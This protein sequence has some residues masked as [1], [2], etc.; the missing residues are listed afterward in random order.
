MVT[1]YAA[2]YVPCLA[3]T[4]ESTAL[5]HLGPDIPSRVTLVPG[6]PGAIG[7]PILAAIGFHLAV[8]TWPLLALAGLFALWYVIATA[9]IAYTD[10]STAGLTVLTAV[11]C[12]CTRLMVEASPS[13][14]TA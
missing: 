4:D 12:M 14:S 3:M 2:K 1:T 8:W 7:L 9:T 6:I 11:T 10:V 5:L 13:L